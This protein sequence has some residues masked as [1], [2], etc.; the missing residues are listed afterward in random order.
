MN[1]AKQIAGKLA[2]GGGALSIGILFMVLGCGGGGSA[3]ADAWYSGG[4]L[5]RA[6]AAEWKMASYSNRLATSADF[7]AKLATSNGR[8]VTIEELKPLA[9][10]MEVCI[11]QAAQGAAADKMDV[12]FLAAACDVLSKPR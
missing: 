3:T 8:N 12:A 2:V 4:S 9:V 10:A 11:S 1:R 5:H 7:A 6:T